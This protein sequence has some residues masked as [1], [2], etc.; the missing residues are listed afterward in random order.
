M[1][2]GDH[3][4]AT[5]SQIDPQFGLHGGTADRWGTFGRCAKLF[6]ILIGEDE[7]V[8]ASLAAYVYTA[9]LGG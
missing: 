8:R 6:H 9:C 1:I 4:Q 5:I 7:V 3:W 2:G